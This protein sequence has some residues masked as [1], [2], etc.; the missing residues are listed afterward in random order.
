[1]VMPFVIVDRTSWRAV[2]STRFWEIDRVNRK[3]EI[4]H[5]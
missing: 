3:Q 1:M 4:G 2:G 5:T